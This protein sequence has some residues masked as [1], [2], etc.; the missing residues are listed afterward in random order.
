MDEATRKAIETEWNRINSPEY[1]RQRAIEKME[2][3]RK[4][5]PSLYETVSKFIP[6]YYQNK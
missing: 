3:Q 2:A 6:N 1:Q 5:E 4:T